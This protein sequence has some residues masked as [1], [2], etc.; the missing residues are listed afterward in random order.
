VFDTYQFISEMVVGPMK[1][2]TNEGVDKK[3]RVKH[4]ILESDF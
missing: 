1:R 4:C 2:D 3:G